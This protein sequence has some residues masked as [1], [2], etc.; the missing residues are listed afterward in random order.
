MASLANAGL[1]LFT[2][3]VEDRQDPLQLGRCRIRVVGCHT[4]D[5]SV[6]PTIDLPWAIPLSPINSAST[7]GIGEAPVGPVEGTWV[8]LFFMD[9]DD[10]QEPVFMGTLNGIPRSAFVN[11]RNPSE[12]FQDP[13]KKYPLQTLLDEPTTNRLARGVSTG[14]IVDLKNASRSTGVPTAF[15]GSWDQPKS[16][17]NALY[18]FNHVFQSESGHVSEYDDSP[19][20]ER[21]HE[22]HKSGTN[23]EIDRNGTLVRRIVGDHFEILERDSHVYIKGKADLTVE[24]DINIY[25]KNNCNLQVDGNLKTEVHGDYSLNVA[26]SIDLVAGKSIAMKGA[27]VGIQG[28]TVYIEVGKVGG[29]V[30]PIFGLSIPQMPQATLT[31]NPFLAKIEATLAKLTSGLSALG[32]AVAIKFPSEPSLPPLGFALSPEQQASFAVEKTKAFAQAN[33]T[34]APTDGR[35]A[36]LEYGNLKTDELTNNAQ[37]SA[38]VKHD[39]TATKNTPDK[40]KCAAGLRVVSAA[41][42][43]L[44]V[45]E[46]GS[47]PGLNT[48]GVVGGGSVPLGVSGRIDQMLAGCGLDNLKQVARTGSGF[49]WCVGAV[50]AWWTSAGL[51]TPS[52]AASCR[53]WA[54]WARSNGYFS[55]TPVIGAAILYGPEGAEHH[56]GIVSAVDDAGNITTIEGNTTGTGF[57]TNGVCVATKTPRTYLGFI[58][59]PPCAS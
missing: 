20:D 43:D 3:V 24:G 1:K 35:Q 21:T 36:A 10:C 53:N 57:T 9:G 37:V 56:M 14:T 7:S 22:Y 13:K 2:G 45:L 47:A 38:P 5:T 27:G 52:G 31:I 48:G 40:Y 44:G 12:G 19:N 23:T 49:S 26:G 46:T 17:F 11:S 18:P 32:S 34:L 42:A 55:S 59:P 51:P 25:V 39:P 29:I 54:S 50:H 41:T 6:L 8:V 16:P 58:I 30:A 4:K 33:D 28:D 15:G